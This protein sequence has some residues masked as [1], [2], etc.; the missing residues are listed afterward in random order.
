MSVFINFKL[1]NDTNNWHS[2]NLKDFVFIILF[3]H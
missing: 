3:N 1:F 2:V